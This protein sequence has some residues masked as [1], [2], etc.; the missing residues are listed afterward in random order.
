[1][2]E[3]LYNFTFNDVSITPYLYRDKFK[4]INKSDSPEIFEVIDLYL[5]RLEVSSPE[6]YMVPNTTNY[7]GIVSRSISLSF[8]KNKPSIFLTQPLIESYSEF[9]EVFKFL[10]AHELIHYFYK[11]YTIPWRSKTG[12]LLK[13]T[14]ANVEGAALAA[15]TKKEIRQAQEFLHENNEGP[16]SRLECYKVGYPDR[17]M[18]SD[19]CTRFRKFDEEVAREVLTDYY[20]Y[21]GKDKS[22]QEKEKLIKRDINNFL[23]Q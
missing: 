16:K 23:N 4:K 14:R 21:M 8:K 5:N 10:L 12:I 11:D 7:E 1:M 19:L 13:E 9:P 6:F 2:K 15:L 3:E 18:I 20:R 17:S 22:E